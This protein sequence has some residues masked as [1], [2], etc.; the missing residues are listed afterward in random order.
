MLEHRLH[1]MEEAERQDRVARL[2]Y[3]TQGR[4]RP[5]NRLSLSERRPFIDLAC[6][7]EN[8]ERR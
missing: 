6:K 3:E 4:D 5:W 1:G 2:L 7:P 8:I